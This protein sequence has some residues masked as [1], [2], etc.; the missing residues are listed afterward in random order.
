M[1]LHL[2]LDVIRYLLRTQKQHL[3]FQTAR[4]QGPAMTEDSAKSAAIFLVA[5]LRSVFSRDRR[6]RMISS[7]EFDLSTMTGIGS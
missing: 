5:D 7:S 2:F 1:L 6:H 3:I 4:A